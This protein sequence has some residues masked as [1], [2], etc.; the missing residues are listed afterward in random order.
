MTSVLDDATRQEHSARNFK[1]ALFIVGGMGLLVGVAASL[2]WGWSGALIALATIGILYSLV[3]QLPPEALMRLYRARRVTEQNS[4][5]LH[6]IMSALSA[7]AELPRQPDLYIIPSALLNAF[8]TGSPERS[9]V[10]VTEGLLRRMNWREIAGVL[11]HEVSHIRHNDLW[12]MGLADI[13]TRFVQMLSYLAL[14]LAGLNLFD[15]MRGEDGV[16]WWAILL[17]YLAPTASSLLQLGLS[18]TREYEA[19][20]EAAALTGDPMGLASALARVEQD[21]GQFWE[22]LAFPIPGRRIPQPSLLRTHPP[23]EQRIARLRELDQ[24]RMAPQIVVT[25]TPMVSLIGVGPIEM[26]PRYR[27]PG[28]YF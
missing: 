6:Q 16:S 5:Q 18:R 3:P 27:W 26:R 13:M 15:M 21:T 19:D 9:A 12:L 23:T 20:L 8:A 7:R 4:V 24:S 25:D 17:L 22:D 1:H 28:V 14:I 2:L 11:G 10:A